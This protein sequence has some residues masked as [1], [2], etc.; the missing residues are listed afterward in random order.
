[1]NVDQMMVL[2]FCILLNLNCRP[3]SYLP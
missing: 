1:M 3:V 2:G